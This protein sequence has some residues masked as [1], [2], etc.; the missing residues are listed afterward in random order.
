[1][2]TLRSEQSA[3]VQPSLHTQLPLLTMPW[4]Q[5][6]PTPQQQ[7]QRTIAAVQTRVLISAMP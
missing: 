3:S 6:P 2:V 5:S 7:Q 1:M 4:T